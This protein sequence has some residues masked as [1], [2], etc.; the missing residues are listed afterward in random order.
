MES[1]APWAELGGFM[2][3]MAQLWTL[4]RALLKLRANGA[5]GRLL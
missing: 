5:A 4:H 2:A 1:I 3:I